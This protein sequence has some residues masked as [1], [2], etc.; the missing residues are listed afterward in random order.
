MT[1]ISRPLEQEE[2]L[3]LRGRA[4]GLCAQ[5]L[6]EDADLQEVSLELREVLSRLEDAPSLRRLEAF[7]AVATPGRPFP[8]GL[9]PY[10]TS[11]ERGPG[12]AGGPTF[13]MADIAGFYRAFGFEVSGERP[14]HIVPELEFV[15]LLLVKEAYARMAGQGEPAE[16]CSTA[17]K[18]FLEEHLGVWLRELSRRSREAQDGIHLQELISLVLVL[19]GP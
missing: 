15:A 8:T 11:H 14:D 19:A 7:L 6:T 17:R 12:S 9:A 18:T 16:V 13:Q 5:L 3:L 1:V 2:R 4:V 10:E